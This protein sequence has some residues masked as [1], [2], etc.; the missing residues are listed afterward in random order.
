MGM[1]SALI[2]C[3]V[4]TKYQDEEDKTSMDAQE[5]ACIA[6]AQELGFTTWDVRRET[7]TGS[8]FYDRPQIMRVIADVKSGKYGALIVWKNDRI[9]RKQGHRAMIK[10]DCLR[11]GA[12]L[13]FVKNQRDDTPEGQ[14][15]DS[16]D[17]YVSEKERATIRERTL[18]GKYQIALKGWLPKA[19]PELYGYRRNA[20]RKRDIH[21]PEAM[22]VCLI[23][24]LIIN[25]RMGAHGVA[26]YL[27]EQRIPPPSEGKMTYPDPDRQPRWRPTQVA[28]MVRRTEYKG[29]TYA[30]KWQRPASAQDKLR[31]DYDPEAGRILRPEREWIKLPDDVTPA[32]VT[33]ETWERAQTIITDVKGEKKRNEGAPHLLRGVVYCETCGRRMYNDAENA[34]T[35]Y[36]RVIY[37]CSSRFRSGTPCGGGRILADELETWVWEKVSDA[38]HHP[39]RIAAALERRRAKGPDDTLIS[40]LETARREYDK[41]DRDQAKLMRRYTTSDASDAKA[42]D[43]L[44]KYTKREMDFLENEKEHYLGVIAEIEQRMADQQHATAQLA[45]VAEYC[46]RVSQNLD[47]FGFD[48]K[49]M[50]IEALEVRITGNGDDWTLFGSIPVFGDGIPKT[51]ALASKSVVEY[52]P[53]HAVGGTHDAAARYTHDARRDRQHLLRDHCA[54]RRARGG[55]A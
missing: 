33:A 50:A 9:S 24:D 54:Q 3:R 21:E 16:I 7:H 46:A 15:Q 39:E 38:L 28:N 13:V 2:Y 8:D 36:R 22:I 26:K 27:N 52:Q 30:W 11:N 25:R 35:A 49:R 51:D 1:R 43:K 48:E 23:F 6:K 4:S 42:D 12:R 14:L 45:S 53:Q 41:C 31:P 55:R 17:D 47:R 19:G 5:A 20:E 32:L 29:E 34:K 44:W 10:E 37:R 40:H 18:G